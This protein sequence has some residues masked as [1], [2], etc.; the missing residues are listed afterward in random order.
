[1]AQRSR[2]EPR[3]AVVENFIRT[4]AATAGDGACIATLNY[5]SLL[6]SAVIGKFSTLRDMGDGLEEV[7][8]ELSPGRVLEGHRLRTSDFIES[9]SC[10]FIALHGSLSWLR[11]GREYV[12]CKMADLRADPNFWDLCIEGGTEWSPAVVLTNQVE[13]KKRVEDCPFNLAYRIFRD[14]LLQSS[15]LLIGGYGFGDECLNSVLRD[16]ALI[17]GGHMRCLVVT[18]GDHPEESAVEGVLPGAN[19]AFWR[20]GFGSLLGSAAWEEWEAA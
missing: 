9:D 10:A 17:S 12:K 13:K 11:R 14:R 20:E 3:Y 4:F 19:L 6:L 15:R 18:H 5:D 16:V 8:V 7:E 1:V 2:G